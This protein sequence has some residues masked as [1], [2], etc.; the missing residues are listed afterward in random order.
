MAR[1][2][3]DTM[4]SPPIGSWNSLLGVDHMVDGWDWFPHLID[5]RRGTLAMECGDDT[6]WGLQLIEMQLTESKI[7]LEDIA[8]ARSH[9]VN[10]A[11]Q[12]GSWLLVQGATL[13]KQHEGH[14]HAV[15]DDRTGIRLWDIRRAGCARITE[16]FCGGMGG[17]SMAVEW[18]KQQGFPCHT[19][20]ALDWDNLATRFFQ[21]NHGGIVHTHVPA[22][23]RE[24]DMPLILH[25]EMS[26]VNVVHLMAVT[27]SNALTS[28]PPC[29]DWSTAS[30]QAGLLGEGG[31][32]II[33][34]MCA[35]RVAAP[36][37]VLLENVAAMRD[38]A[39]WSMIHE[40]IRWAGFMIAEYKIMDLADMR[41]IRRPRLVILLI[42][43][44][45]SCASVPSMPWYKVPNQSLGSSELEELRHPDEI[46]HQV[47][48]NSDLVKF[49]SR[50][51]YMPARWTTSDGIS[52]PVTAR[53]VKHSDKVNTIMR[54]YSQQHRISHEK[55]LKKKLLAQLHKDETGF[56]FFTPVEILALHGISSPI[57]V[58]I[59][60]RHAFELVGNMIVPLCALPGV[61]AIM[62]SSIHD[63]EKAPMDYLRRYQQQ[64]WEARQINVGC[65]EDVAVI[66]GNFLAQSNDIAPTAPWPSQVLEQIVCHV[67]PHGI[68]ESCG[69]AVQGGPK[70]PATF[71]CEN[72]ADQVDVS[73]HVI[74]CYLE[75]AKHEI[76]CEAAERLDKV[77]RH[78]VD[79]VCNVI[80][81]SDHDRKK[82]V[83]PSTRGTQIPSPIRVF[84]TVRIVNPACITNESVAKHFREVI[85]LMW[86]H[87]HP[88]VP[89][90]CLEVSV[91]GT[92]WA[93]CAV[94]INMTWRNVIVGMMYAFSIKPK[95]YHEIHGHADDKWGYSLQALIS[96]P[97]RETPV[98]TCINLVWPQQ[99]AGE[100][101]PHDS[102][103][104]EPA[105]GEEC[106]KHDIPRKKLWHECVQV[107]LPY[108]PASTVTILPD[109]TAS[110][111]ISLSRDQRGQIQLLE[112]A[113]RALDSWETHGGV[114]APSSE[115]HSKA[116]SRS[117]RK[118][119][120]R[121]KRWVDTVQEFAYNACSHI[122]VLASLCMQK[123]RGFGKSPTLATTHVQP[124][125]SKT[126]S[127]TLQNVWIRDLGGKLHIMS[128]HK[129]SRLWQIV[130][131]KWPHLEGSVQLYSGKQRLQTDMCVSC[132][133]GKEV[134]SLRAFPIRGGGKMD[135]KQH[136]EAVVATVL[137][138][139]GYPPASISQKAEQVV[140]KL[141]AP[142]INKAMLTGG[143][144]YKQLL[145]IAEEV[146]V[147]IISEPEERQ[148]SASRIQKALREKRKRQP[149]TIAADDYQPAPGMFLNEDNTE[150][151]ILRSYDGQGTGVILMNEAKAS[152][153]I[154]DKNPIC[155]DELAII[156]PGHRSNN[157]GQGWEISF[158]AVNR[159][160]QKCVL[161]GTLIQ[162]GQKK[163]KLT[164]N[165]A[166]KTDTD[167]QTTITLA[168]WA[169]DF[170][171]EDWGKMQRA[172]VRTIKM[173]LQS[174]K[175]ENVLMDVWGRSYRNK[176]SKV[177]PE[178]ATS[179]MV[180]ALVKNSHAPA[181][182][183]KSGFSKVFISA[184]QEGTKHDSKHAL[185]WIGSSKAETI[186]AANAYP[187]HCGYV[188][189]KN[190]FA[191]R[192]DV[193]N[194]EAA[195]KAIMPEVQYKPQMPINHL[196][197]VM[198]V[199]FG[200]T[201]E[202]WIDIA[203]KI[204]WDMRPVKKLGAS[205]WLL[206]AKEKP[207]V[208]HIVINDTMC[209]LKEV[210]IRSNASHDVIRAGPKPKQA[211]SRDES[212]KSLASGKGVQSDPWLVNDPWKTSTASGSEKKTPPRVVE[213]PTES[214][215]NQQDQQI[216]ELREA[217]QKI[218][219]QHTK[220]VTDNEV[221][222]KQLESAFRSDMSQLM[223]T[224][225]GSQETFEKNLSASISQA[226]A[227]QLEDLRDL[228]KG[229]SPEK[230]KMKQQQ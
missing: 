134:L 169:D 105:V 94:P 28:S 35:A 197:K 180:W 162:K 42:N 84:H 121:E 27:K 70:G 112:W 86:T 146:E 188:R 218:D 212:R 168:A 214:R 178:H 92:K 114:R 63:A 85:S 22:C 123:S 1:P 40:T 186:K 174:T 77:I 230:K 185:I 60:V 16:L 167:G 175:E 208:D 132:L 152:Q 115:H 128:A 8:L 161:A 61:L 20:A 39:H 11:W 224:V 187:G 200:I 54:M 82:V 195:H 95:V 110:T 209:M 147:Q 189:G 10:S 217:V 221:K 164:S 79:K 145:L 165:M 138:E 176:G 13:R 106:V 177:E 194:H 127:A 74:T 88:D 204:K 64:I 149:T 140:E 203:K 7:F 179:I 107:Q 220:A 136:A 119:C 131:D 41:A 36:L 193:A 47:R 229:A 154:C 120:L 158:I 100:D 108:V 196:Y 12:G 116:V 76:Q 96:K 226:M 24:N 18:C 215:L 125:Q 72:A 101:A 181:L 99:A 73:A 130:R 58:P 133:V 23:V 15:C 57:H 71:E 222:M 102:D 192:V 207:Q 111:G 210:G 37:W 80:V 33:R 2:F 163:V 117:L 104:P 216:R 205:V 141:G 46:M 6:G 81:I 65:Q 83:Q 171:E 32:E 135:N 159:E 53:V 153:W 142:R 191:L 56:R 225:K 160:G 43:K 139:K 68:A 126:C 19:V 31:R 155:S 183:K 199:E 156:I 21:L 223:S 49:Y 34:T 124:C 150:T 55:L 87:S 14:W 78:L 206:G 66:K 172:P 75:G 51:E 227:Q 25:D 144:A 170:N 89:I 184:R 97:G 109:G 137:L 30:S 44:S 151:A 211:D 182:L 202:T 3:G 201:H 17:W 48:L 118:R 98:K 26:V 129:Q 157:L 219:A 29:P 122:Q 5:G 62:C 91:Q 190:G 90:H 166:T 113:R 67:E 93:E 173:L 148:M 69:A 45:I 38:H 103:P 9:L 228:V 59:S 52:E 50:Q 143:N 4:V 198:P 213:G